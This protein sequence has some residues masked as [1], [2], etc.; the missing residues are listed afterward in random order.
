MAPDGYNRDSTPRTLNISAPD[1]NE[2]YNTWTN[3]VAKLS[4]TGLIVK[5]DETDNPW[6]VRARAF[7]V[8]EEG[9]P[10][11]GA[12]FG[13]Y[14]TEADA[15][16]KLRAVAML[17]TKA[18]GYTDTYTS[19]KLEEDV[20]SYTL[21]CREVASPPGYALSDTIYTKTFIRTSE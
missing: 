4:N 17:E 10:L 6:K 5:N 2:K 8:D 20:S 3:P 7:K 19:G 12:W 1:K 21:Y 14:R 11:A 16:T 9:K 18:D 15:K 13:F